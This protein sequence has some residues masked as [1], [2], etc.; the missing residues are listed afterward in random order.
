M[1]L[2]RALNEYDIV[3]DPTNN[4]I[5][6][7]QMIY[8]LTKEYYDN[9]KNLEYMSLNSKEKNIFIRE[10]MDE[11][12]ISHIHKLEKSFIKRNKLYRD[13][14]NALLNNHNPAGYIMFIKYM[15][16]LQ[17]HLHNGS[18]LDTNWISTS[19]TI[20]GVKKYY[21]KQETH[22]IAII[23]S[24]TNGIIDS[25][26]ILTVDVSSNEKIS[27][28]PYLYNKIQCDNIE[29]LAYL[30]TQFPSILD[31]F[32]IDYLINTSKKSLG[33]TYSK[34]SDEVCIYEY[35][36]KEHII[37]IIEAL[38]FDLIKADPFNFNF[39]KLDKKEQEI[40]LKKLKS[41]LLKL[42]KQENNPYLLYVFEQL[43]LNNKNIN[44][45]ITLTDSR[46][47]II[48]N[49]NKILKLARIIPNIQT[50]R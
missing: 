35:I 15:S 7:K 46:E 13:T 38:Q 26:H 21:D 47:K 23:T 28:N 18:R 10:H 8:N 36:P 33:F 27:N 25:D 17:N 41:I 32:N 2:L 19:K 45:L 40:Q 50:K 49:R 9:S 12:L 4:G 16:T 44:S 3:S 6:S 1:L 37:G 11:Y 39:F 24:N 48:Y 43:Y 5:A 20:D 14:M 29:L 31:D 30:S 22:S 34:K 42:I